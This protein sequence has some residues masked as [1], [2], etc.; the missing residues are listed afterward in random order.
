MERNDA[1][2]TQ[3][4]QAL[5]HLNQPCNLEEFACYRGSPCHC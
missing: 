4:A 1:L 5:S 3:L 2:D